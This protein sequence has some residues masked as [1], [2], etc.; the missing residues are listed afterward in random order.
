MG[1]SDKDVW[2]RVGFDEKPF[3][4][5]VLSVG[6]ETWVGRKRP[7]RTSPEPDGP[8]RKGCLV[9]PS[10]VLGRLDRTAATAHAHYLIAYTPVAPGEAD[11]AF[12]RIDAQSEITYPLL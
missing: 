1:K 6:D 11:A 5:F 3:D 9:E 10:M 8:R 7:A 4:V 2:L 12:G